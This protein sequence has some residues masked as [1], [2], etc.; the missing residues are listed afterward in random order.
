[1]RALGLESK[2]KNTIQSFGKKN[3]KIN[4]NQFLAATVS[5]KKAFTKENIKALFD[6]FDISRKGYITIDEFRR[7]NPNPHDSKDIEKR[8]RD[9]REREFNDNLILS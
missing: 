3:E 2:W 9:L 6:T 4:L 7:T 1:M 8:R 5:K